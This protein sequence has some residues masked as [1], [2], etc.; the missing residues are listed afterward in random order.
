MRVKAIIP[1]GQ[2]SQAGVFDDFKGDVAKRASEAGELR[3]NG[4]AL[5]CKMSTGGGNLM[6]TCI[7]PKSTMTMSLPGDLER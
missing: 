1:V 6:G 5:L 7:M 2:M 4:E 3:E